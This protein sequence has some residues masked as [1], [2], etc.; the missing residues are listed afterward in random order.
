MY[1]HNSFSHTQ[2]ETNLLKKGFGNNNFKYYKKTIKNMEVT[3]LLS[4]VILLVYVFMAYLLGRIVTKYLEY[5]VTEV[6]S[7]EWILAKNIINSI[8]IPI[9]LLLIGLTAYTVVKVYNLFYFYSLLDTV[10]FVYFV[11]LSAIF[12][13]RIGSLLLN[14]AL[15][16]YHHIKKVP[17][18]VNGLV[19]LVVYITAFVIILQHFNVEITPFIATLG[20]GGLAVGLALQTTLSNF[21]A[22]VNVMSDGSLNVGDYIEIEDAKGWIEDMGSIYTKIRTL[23]N[24]LIILPNSKL[25]TSIIINDS[26]PMQEVTFWL[27]C[28]VAY[29][30]DLEKVEKVT[31]KVAKKVQNEVEGAVKEF[32]PFI[33]FNEFGQSNINFNIIIKVETAIDVF[34]VRHELIKRIKKA[35]DKEKIEI[36]WP[37]R[38]VVK[39]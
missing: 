23:Q 17:H 9:Y 29:T 13:S 27:P 24:K 36:S 20:I 12:I 39:G 38:K 11:I 1:N 25:A 31:L 15:R 35:Y 14:K 21:F 4:I 28:G 18:L 5:L 8:I 16:M 37:V 7:K 32:E 6:L 10:F 26:K 22:G 30:S 19:I 2:K 33:R 34:R 3:L